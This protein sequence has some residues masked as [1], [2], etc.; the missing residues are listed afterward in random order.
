MRSAQSRILAK[1]SF[2]LV[3]LIAH[4]RAGFGG[5]LLSCGLLV[6]AVVWKMPAPAPRALWQALAISGACGFGWLL[7]SNQRE[8]LPRCPASGERQSHLEGRKLCGVERARAT[9]QHH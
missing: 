9:R 8:K 6:T 4:D 5:G 7:D 3:P 1:R 2:S